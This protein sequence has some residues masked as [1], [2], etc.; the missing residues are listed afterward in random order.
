MH[1][2]LLLHLT[3]SSVASPE[4]KDDDEQLERRL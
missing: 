4:V 3:F 1:T 2:L